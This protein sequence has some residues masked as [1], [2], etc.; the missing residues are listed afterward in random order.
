ME[1]ARKNKLLKLAVEMRKDILRMT[2]KAG[3]NG[4][5]AGG[6][7]SAVEIL[8]VLYGAILDQATSNRDLRDRFI[9]SKGHCVMAQYAAMARAGLLDP[10]ELEKFEDEDSWLCSH[11]TQDVCHGIEFSTGSLGQGLSLGIGMA[12]GLLRKGN[13]KSR[14]F[15]LLGDGECNEGQIW[16][17]AASAAHFG[18]A[19]IVAIIDANGMQLDGET[20]GI[21]DMGD[22]AAKWSAFGWDAAT[23]NGHD[24]EALYAALIAP[25]TRPLAC[26][27]MTLKGKGI[28]FMENS[29]AWHHG[30]LGR[31]QFEQAMAELEGQI[32][33]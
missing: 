32:Y 4:A 12:M 22:L 9:M 1:T 29:P 10:L 2:L 25:R 13:Q 11:A 20:C 15:V 24:P 31:K 33:A 17:A 26:I 5:H 21:L 8:A 18:L 16:E 30:R 6:A 14:V 28:S 7:L 27:A 3:A 19:N 23:V